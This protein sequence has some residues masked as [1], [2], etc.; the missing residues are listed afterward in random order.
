MA[1]AFVAATKDGAGLS[2]AAAAPVAVA[3]TLSEYA[4]NPGVLHCHIVSHAENDDGL[5]GMVTALI[6]K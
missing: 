3:V 6:V 1:V 5:T 2:A 4:I